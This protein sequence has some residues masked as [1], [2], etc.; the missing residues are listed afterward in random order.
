MELAAYQ[1]CIFTGEPSELLTRTAAMES[2]L[3]CVPMKS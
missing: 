2:V 3:W 1:P